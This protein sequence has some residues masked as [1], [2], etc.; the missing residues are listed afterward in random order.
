MIFILHDFGCD[1]PEELIDA[2]VFLCASI[3]KDVQIV[4][5]AEFVPLFERNFFLAVK[6]TFVRRDCQGDVRGRIL[7]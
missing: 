4:L 7:P 6:V 2:D 5:E 3:L 1:L